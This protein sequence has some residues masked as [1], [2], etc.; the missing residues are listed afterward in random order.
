MNQYKGVDDFKTLI[1]ELET[2]TVK[3]PKVKE[4]L[5]AMMANLQR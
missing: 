3:I 1:K 2:E 5:Q 4:G